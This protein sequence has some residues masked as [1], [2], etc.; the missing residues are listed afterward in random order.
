[1][2]KTILISL[3]VG[4]SVGP[5]LAQRRRD[6]PVCSKPADADKLVGFSIKLLLPKDGV[7][8]QVRDIDYE[9]WGI[10]FGSPTNRIELTG[11]SGLNVGNGEVPREYLTASRKFSGRIWAHNKNAAW[12]RTGHSRT[13]GSGGT[14]ECLVKRWD[15]SMSLLKPPLTSIAFWIRYAFSI[16]HATEQ[17]HAPDAQPRSLSSRLNEGAGDAGRYMASNE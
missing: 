17:R 9:A 5:V 3:L 7:F 6:I 14:L 2:I 16:D 11:Y 4:A 10:G 8:K 13:A 1:M 12:M 15:T